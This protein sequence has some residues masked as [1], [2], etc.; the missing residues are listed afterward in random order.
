VSNK[1]KCEE[2]KYGFPEVD[3]NG[4]CPKCATER[5]E[6]VKFLEK[7]SREY[8]SIKSKFVPVN[9]VRRDRR[10]STNRHAPSK[11]EDNWGS[12]SDYAEYETSE[13]W[14]SLNTWRAFQ[15]VG[16]GE[17]STDQWKSLYPDINLDEVSAKSIYKR[18]ADERMT[19]G[20]RPLHPKEWIQAVVFRNDVD[21]DSD[22]KVVIAQQSKTTEGTDDALLAPEYYDTPSFWN[23]LKRCAD[24]I[25]QNPAI[26]KEA[27]I[28]SV[29]ASYVADSEA[30][31]DRYH[32]LDNW[33][34][35]L[36]QIVRHVANGTPWESKLIPSAFPPPE[37]TCESCGNVFEILNDDG[38]CID[39]VIE[40][41]RERQ[42]DE[43]GQMSP[44]EYNQ[45]VRDFVNSP[46]GKAVSA[47]N[48]HVKVR[49]E[50]RD[51]YVAPKASEEENEQ[52]SREFGY[53]NVD[54][55]G[56][57][58]RMDYHDHIRRGMYE[59]AQGRFSHREIE[60]LYEFVNTRV[61]A[62]KTEEE[63]N[64][65]FNF[66]VRVRSADEIANRD[67]HEI[68]VDEAIEKWRAGGYQYGGFETQAEL[69]AWN[70][71]LAEKESKRVEE[72][73]EWKRERAVIEDKE[74]KYAANVKAIASGLA[75]E[76]KAHA[77]NPDEPKSERYLYFEE[78]TKSIARGFGVTDTDNEHLRS[79]HTKIA[80][81]EKLVEDLKKI[82]HGLS[83]EQEL[84]KIAPA[85]PKSER[86]LYFEQA[87]KDLI[88]GKG[89]PTEEPPAK[90]EHKRGAPTS[91][92]AVVDI[93]EEQYRARR[94]S[95]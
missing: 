11:H 31:H 79:E 14:K 58:V 90:P 4:L 6:A 20:A 13:F 70:K 62:S 48:P 35:A 91:Y 27:L 88:A 36:Y 12:P 68:A 55:T 59:E 78:A 67:E 69:D 77:L 23:N 60:G 22:E 47:A 44:S 57:A 65:W 74:K 3:E 52:D 54:V 94:G 84:H 2:C 66:P 43:D 17:I 56:F 41:E 45:A 25:S 75:F 64:A 16:K 51:D 28:E 40:E 50:Y 38:L 49:D 92:S 42:S 26:D 46:F 87:T 1:P 32:T 39:C 53:D 19:S 95:N 81:R 21:E 29:Y 15:N 9:P 63:R 10:D 37:N 76:R 24:A 73:I 89:M 83:E 33:R 8:E 72:E 7:F 82:A 61:S 80:D 34:T 5:A 71:E 86:L 85:E 93:I 30:E 18:Y